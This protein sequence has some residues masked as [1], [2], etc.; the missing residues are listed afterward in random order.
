MESFFLGETLGSDPIP[1]CSSC[2]SV[3]N[4]CKFCSFESALC[5]AQDE[6]EYRYLKDNCKFEA[7][8]GRLVSK[9]PWS[10]DPAI[11]QDNGSQALVFQCKLEARQLKENTFV[12]YAKCFQDIIDVVS[13]ISPLE[14]KAWKGPVNLN[15]HHDV[16]KDSTT[17]PI[18]LV[19]NSS[20]SNGSTALNDL[21]VKGP[22]TLNC[23]FTNLVIF[24]G[25]EVALVG[26]ISK[27]YNSIK[28]GKVEHHARRYWFRF[29][30]N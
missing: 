4:E 15:T 23:L 20:F 18:R 14:L 7:S 3:F 11:L 21:L 6:L 28:T 2:K 1:S 8:V 16:L 13:K 19:S 5:S 9:Y 24:R 25:Y 12:E 17:T 30:Q 29:S 27:A 26:N 22:N 10:S